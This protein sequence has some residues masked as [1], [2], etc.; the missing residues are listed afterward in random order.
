MILK[1]KCCKCQTSHAL[2]FFLLSSVNVLVLRFSFCLLLVFVLFSNKIKRQEKDWRWRPSRRRCR[3]WRSRRTTWWTDA[4]PVS[5][6]CIL[7]FIH[8][9]S[10][11]VLFQSC[12]DAKMRREKT[13]EEVN[14]LGNKSKTLEVKSPLMIVSVSSKS[15][16][17][18]AQCFMHKYFPP[19]YISLL[20]NYKKSR[21]V[22]LSNR[23][24]GKLKENVQCSECFKYLTVMS[25]KLGKYSEARHKMFSY[26]ISSVN[27]QPV[28]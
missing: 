11:F 6:W 21:P 7:N 20:S 15:N 24:V 26:I 8:L 28:F 23:L 14:E 2:H 4:T 5:R 19:L 25:H 13:E 12:R 17:C 16:I 1:E 22:S 18:L 10:Y 9:F 27:L 3:P